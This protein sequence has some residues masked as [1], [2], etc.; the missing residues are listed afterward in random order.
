MN[1]A[2]T[3]DSA[4]SVGSRL[5]PGMGGSR[6]DAIVLCLGRANGH[7]TST[8]RLRKPKQPRRALSVSTVLNRFLQSEPV[9]R[10]TLLLF[11]LVLHYLLQ[12]QP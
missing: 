6:A 9:L 8:W 7:A 3:Q 4:C 1:L 2:G 10:R 12:W 11:N 5:P